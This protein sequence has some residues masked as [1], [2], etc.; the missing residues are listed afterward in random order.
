[1]TNFPAPE[2]L[3]GV[4]VGGSKTHIRIERADTG[5]I[6][7]DTI[8]SST[9]W[10]GLSDSDRA[11]ALA[12]LVETSTAGRGTVASLV[13]GVHGND[14]REQEEVLQTPI[15]SQYP[16]VRILN[17][18]HLLVLAHGSPSGTGL[19]A[20][21]GSSATSIQSDG[22]ALTVGGWG[23]LLGDEGGA[24]GIVRD[25]ARQVLH[26][27]DSEQV[28]PLTNLLLM[29]LEVDHPHGLQHRLT[30]TEPR[31][32]ARAA[33]QVFA[34]LE[35]GSMRAQA[36]IDAHAEAMA[37]MIELLARRG[38]DVSTVVCA[39]GVITNQPV[40]FEAVRASIKAR[41]CATRDVV[42]LKEPPV[43]GAIILARKLYQASEREHRRVDVTEKR[44]ALN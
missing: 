24:V 21:T 42:L 28:D 41:V 44:S 25:A 40:L 29:G 27:Y 22:E 17:D 1:M 20:G 7:H 38:G 34:A 23:W 43:S 5:A 8:H 32:W 14:S 3:V 35:V 2:L 30:A 11:H 18:S 33:E 12:T 16:I 13:A 10:A 15:R 26:A 19:I 36:V 31:E 37:G 6:L 9:G 4:D 39:G